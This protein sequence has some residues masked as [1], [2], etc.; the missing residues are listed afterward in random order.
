MPDYGCPCCPERFVS[1]RQSLVH[2]VL[3][4]PRLLKITPNHSKVEKLRLQDLA[5][6]IKKLPKRIIIPKEYI[7]TFLP[8]D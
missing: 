1:A 5:T 4:H 7:G 3:I 2:I 6:K 8:R